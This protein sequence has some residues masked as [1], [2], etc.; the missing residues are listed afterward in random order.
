MGKKLRKKTRSE[1]NS[2][3][4]RIKDKDVLDT[5]YL[6][7]EGGWKYTIRQICERHD[8]SKPTFYAILKRNGI[9]R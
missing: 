1:I 3:N 6:T 2:D 8:I 9:R 7:D 4:R 5:F